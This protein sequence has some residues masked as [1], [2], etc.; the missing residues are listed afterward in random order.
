MENL[1]Q[2]IKEAS[3]EDVNLCYQCDK[4]T[5]GCPVAFAMERSPAQVIHAAQLGLSDLVF[6]SN[7]IWLCASC[8]TCTTRCPQ[9]LDISKVMDALRIIARRERIPPKVPE[10]PAFYEAALTSLK[11]TGSLFEAGVSTVMKLKTGTLFK[12]LPLAR[13]FLRKG[14]LALFPN[15][16]NLR[17]VR[18]VN[19]IISRVKRYERF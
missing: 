9:G 18:R 3:G 11:L 17:N 2:K 1:A 16:R 12:D 5:S 6:K 4:C 19:Q 14:R 10:V 7:T 13:E 15:L 8:E